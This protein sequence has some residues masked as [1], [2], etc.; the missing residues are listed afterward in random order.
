MAS[1]SDTS[2]V[3]EATAELLAARSNGTTAK[4]LTA[5]VVAGGGGGAHARDGEPPGELAS[6][7]RTYEKVRRIGAGACGV[8]YA[9][10]DKQS[11]QLVAVKFPH[12]AYADDERRAFRI[13][14]HIIPK[15][16]VA[17][18]FFGAKHLSPAYE[19]IAVPAMPGGMARE[20]WWHSLLQSRRAVAAGWIQRAAS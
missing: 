16:A 12:A 1:G 14:Q 2:G 13:S 4:Q 3:I 5:M 8:A 11:G 17:R 15:H 18:G 20:T 9:Y 6:N 19:N 7:G 10:R